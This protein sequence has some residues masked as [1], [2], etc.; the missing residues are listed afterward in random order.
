VLPALALVLAGGGWLLHYLHRNPVVPSTDTPSQAH[1][2]AQPASVASTEN[3]SAEKPAGNSEEGLQLKA[4][5]E[6]AM[7]QFVHA[8][9]AIDSIGADKW[10]G[11]AYA[12]MTRLA[13]AADEFVLKASYG[14]AAEAYRS[15]ASLADDIGSRAG[16][17]F[18]RLMQEGRAAFAEG[19]GP[20]AVE[21]F[22]TARMIDPGNELAQ[23][24]LQRSEKLPAVMQLLTSGRRHEDENQLAQALAS[25]REA[26][27]LDPFSEAAKNDMTRVAEKI[28]SERFQNLMSTGL[29]AL[30][31]G[32]LQQARALLLQARK[33]RPN[34]VEA[35][36]ALA[37]TEQAIRL[38]RI[39]LL[40]RQATAAE[41]G[42]DWQQALLTYRDVLK[43]DPTV[44]FAVEGK[45]R[46]E[47]QIDIRRRVDF[48]IQKPDILSSD[49]QLQN[50]V[51]LIAEAELLDP[52]GPRLTDR[53]TE[54]KKL[55]DLART[56]VTVIIESDNLTTVAVY[57][58]GRLGRFDARELRLR[59]GTYTVVG[60]RDGY[61]DVRRDIVVTPGQNSIRVTIACKVK[62]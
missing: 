49:Q 52:A 46:A 60:S 12:D 7:T 62:V 15:A 44:Q 58:V 22:A 54:L 50:A 27:E 9:Q 21:L 20:A 42:E 61:R 35:E 33:L 53:V 47:Q 37:Q 18:D 41:R 48:F 3:G 28:A 24:S 13:E 45:K 43:I 29:N 1:G 59:P 38:D 8:R 56:E 4:D 40:Q 39:H 23:R 17:A 25:Y 34:S 55:V 31:E 30:H 6:A 11:E 5:A 14:P 51:S 36:D 32:D 19:N 26:L 10:A 16:A 57:R 2:T